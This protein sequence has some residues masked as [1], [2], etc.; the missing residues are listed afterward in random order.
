MLEKFR[1]NLLKQEII[2]VREWIPH[3]G[4]L[5]EIIRLKLSLIRQNTQFLRGY[6]SRDA[7]TT[8]ATF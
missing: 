5:T 1:A 6:Y 3:I 2:K 7:W 4:P 8:E